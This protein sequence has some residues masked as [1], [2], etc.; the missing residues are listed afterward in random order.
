MP[1]LDLRKQK[2]WFIW[3]LFVFLY[4][5]ETNKT[6]KVVH[7]KTRFFCLWYAATIELK[8]MICEEMPNLKLVSHSCIFCQQ[9]IL[10]NLVYILCTTLLFPFSF[11]VSDTFP[12]SSAILNVVDSFV[13]LNW[14]KW[15]VTKCKNIKI[16][17]CY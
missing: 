1:C 7:P 11:I 13:L 10:G 2:P 17:G 8:H 14:N 16:N 6:C 3:I 15:N 12:L 9:T 5:A 4:Y